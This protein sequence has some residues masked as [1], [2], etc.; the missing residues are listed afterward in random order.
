M[1]K[2]WVLFHLKEAL[3]EIESTIKEIESEPEYD[4]PEFSV[5]IAHLYHHVNTA[6]NSRH[7]SDEETEEC[8][9]SNFNEWRQFPSDVAMSC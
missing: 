7:S 4:E 9:E 5:A 6:W 1:N 3:E 2:E 8:S